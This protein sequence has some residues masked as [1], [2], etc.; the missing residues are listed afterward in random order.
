MLLIMRIV[1]PV[2]RRLH[3]LPMASE[4]SSFVL[5]EREGIYIGIRYQVVPQE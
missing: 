3:S 4:T 1:V 2:T 5:K